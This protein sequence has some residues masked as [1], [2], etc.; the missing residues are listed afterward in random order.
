MNVAIVLQAFSFYF[1]SDYFVAC[2][3]VQRGLSPLHHWVLLY[4][5]AIIG[6]LP[7]VFLACRR[8]SQVYFGLIISYITFWGIAFYVAHESP[9][10]DV[11]GLEIVILFGALMIWRCKKAITPNV[12][13]L[14]G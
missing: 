1:V 13:M 9:V 3:W 8:L 5:W 10:A 2:A 12:K 6:T 7:V 14:Q 11:S 4:V